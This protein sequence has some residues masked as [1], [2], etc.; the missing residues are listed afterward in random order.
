MRT[1]IVHTIRLYLHDGYVHLVHILY[2][3]MH[4]RIYTYATIR[5]AYATATYTIVR[6]LSAIIKYML[7]Q[8]L[9]TAIII[10]IE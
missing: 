6:K 7:W 4:V 2:I 3:F 10:Y 9:R 5:Y 8:K 1:Y